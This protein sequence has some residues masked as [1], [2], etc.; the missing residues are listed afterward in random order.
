M[1]NISYDLQRIGEEDLDSDINN[2]SLCSWIKN[3]K[4]CNIVLPKVK[5]I[6]KRIEKNPITKRCVTPAKKYLYQLRK[7]NFSPDPFRGERKVL[8]DSE[9]IGFLFRNREKVK[10]I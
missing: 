3:K 10:S 9:V 2:Q 7:T 4:K 1:E 8:Q 5:L 6:P